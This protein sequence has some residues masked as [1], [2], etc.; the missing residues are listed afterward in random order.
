[1]Q[2]NLFCISR[3]SN[4]TK[5]NQL[6]YVFLLLFLSS[7][8]RYIFTHPCPFFFLTHLVVFRLL[9]SSFICLRAALLYP[10]PGLKATH[11]MLLCYIILQCGCWALS[12]SVIFPIAASVWAVFC[13]VYSGAGAGL[14]WG[15]SLRVKERQRWREWKK[16]KW[17]LYK[18]PPRPACTILLDAP[19]TAKSSLEIITAWPAGETR[20]FIIERWN[21]LV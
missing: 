14:G 8:S 7:C 9:P 5:Q 4:R 18:I 17:G 19:S 20:G 21:I 13:S 11:L 15:K 1:M 12:R 16:G 6:S 3:S 2:R 10:T